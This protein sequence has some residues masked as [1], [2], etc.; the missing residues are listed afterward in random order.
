VDREA[1]VVTVQAMFDD[2]AEKLIAENP[3][4]EHARMMNAFGL[5]TNGKFFAMVVK[6]ELVVK[7]PRERVDELVAGGKGR[8]FDP[9]H[10][11][12]MKEWAT[13]RPANRRVC[14]GYVEEAR[15]FVS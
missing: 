7:L 1:D 12:L 5:K 15:S 2:V 14:S 3:S 8:R 4:I 13:L 6:D 10:G 11:R 9:G